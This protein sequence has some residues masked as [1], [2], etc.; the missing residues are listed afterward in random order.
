MAASPHFWLVLFFG[1]AIAWPWYK[2][3]YRHQGARLRSRIGYGVFLSTGLIFFW[4][5]HPK[6]RPADFTLFLMVA[7]FWTILYLNHSIRRLRTGIRGKVMRYPH[8]SRW[9]YALLLPVPVMMFI[10]DSIRFNWFYLGILFAWCVSSIFEYIYV[11]RLELR[12]GAPI[13]EQ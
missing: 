12:L 6:L 4:L 10:F 11:Q 13:M 2:G 1:L 8:W 9:H 5:L 7:I 3:L